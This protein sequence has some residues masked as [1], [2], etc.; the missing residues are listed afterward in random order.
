MGKKNIVGLASL[1]AGLSMDEFNTPKY[2]KPKYLRKGNGGSVD[3]ITKMTEEEKN[4][5]NGLKEFTYG[6]ET[7]W[8]LNKKNADKKASKKGLI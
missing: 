6:N 8:A 7:I 1:L 3:G 2:G 4:I 5:S